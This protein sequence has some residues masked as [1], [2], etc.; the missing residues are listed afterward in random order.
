MILGNVAALSEPA[1]TGIVPRQ[2]VVSVIPDHCRENSSTSRGE[3]LR[4]FAGAPTRRNRPD[5]VSGRK[6]G[7]EATSLEHANVEADADTNILALETR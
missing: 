1:T 7:L 2:R 5:P 3:V 4:V 6:V